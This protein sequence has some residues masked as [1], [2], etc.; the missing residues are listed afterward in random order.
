MQI[1][2]ATALNWLAQYREL[3]ESF[4]FCISGYYDQAGIL[5]D[6]LAQT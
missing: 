2:P 5:G 3:Y 1:L 4:L 6:V